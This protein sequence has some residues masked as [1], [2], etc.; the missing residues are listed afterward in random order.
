MEI[1]KAT[2]TRHTFYQCGCGRRGGDM[3]SYSCSSDIHSIPRCQN[4]DG[5]PNR[6]TYFE[7]HRS[8]HVKHMI[9]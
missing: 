4:L 2:V 9:E 3:E 8:N 7:V 5:P 6:A 1:G